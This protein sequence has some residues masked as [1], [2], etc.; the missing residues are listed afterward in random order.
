MVTLL[1]L[2]LNCIPCL[3]SETVGRLFFIAV[4]TKRA[5][6]S[7]HVGNSLVILLKNGL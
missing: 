4:M 3:F 2:Q 7:R 1:Y 5:V 6:V